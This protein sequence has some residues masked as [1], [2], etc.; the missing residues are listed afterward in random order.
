LSLLLG[1]VASVGCNRPKLTK[2]VN[3]NAILCRQQM[4]VGITNT[5]TN[6]GKPFFE[7]IKLKIKT[8]KKITKF[9]I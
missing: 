4:Q 1:I 3:I 9:R 6:T 8:S 5:F 7:L 2:L